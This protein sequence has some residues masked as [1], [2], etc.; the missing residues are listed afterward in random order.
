[1]VKESIGAGAQAKDIKLLIN[2]MNVKSPRFY[3]GDFFIYSDTNYT[4]TK[5]N[6]KESRTRKKN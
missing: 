3:L 4:E 2:G 1:M 5:K 6:T